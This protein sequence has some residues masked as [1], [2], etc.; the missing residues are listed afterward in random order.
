MRGFWCVLFILLFVWAYSMFFHLS[1]QGL[2]EHLSLNQLQE[3]TVRCITKACWAPGA[4]N[5]NQLSQ[6]QQSCI[7]QA[8]TEA[9]LNMCNRVSSGGCEDTKLGPMGLYTPG[10]NTP[11]IR[12]L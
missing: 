11:I 7:N 10:G 5:R 3:P 4:A 6:C 1:Y 12:S 8:N 9:Q 2:K